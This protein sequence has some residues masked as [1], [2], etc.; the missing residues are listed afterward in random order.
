MSQDLKFLQ[1][2]WYQILKDHGFDDIEQSNGSLKRWSTEVSLLYEPHNIESKQEYYR[3]ARIFLEHH[4]FHS[5]TQREIWALY[6]DGIP[7][8]DI[9]KILTNNGKPYSKDKVQK[10][11]K[12]LITLMKKKWYLYK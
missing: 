5:K 2:K 8:R 11:L 3:R 1:K 12:P 7:Y 10:E 6:S 9:A 4:R